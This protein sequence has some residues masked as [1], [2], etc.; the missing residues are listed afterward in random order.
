MAN[1]AL[2]RNILKGDSCGYSLM[3]ITDIYLANYGDV[4]ATTLAEDCDPTSGAT[5]ITAITMATGG[6]FFH[7]EGQKNSISYTDDL[8]VTDAGNKYRTHTLT[9]TLPG[10]YNKD[11]VCSV[12][13]LALGRFIAV[14]VTA[15]GQWL[16]LGRGA[17][18]EATEQSIAGG[19]D[20]NGV[21]I[22]LAADV[23]E[24]SVPL[25]A[26]A[27]ATVKGE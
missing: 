23:A 24:S 15:D 16:M 11:L 6:K 20:A 14:V 3:K 18:L 7:I 4:S 5:E 21:T 27:Q 12:D 25:S 13:A 26:A 2:N 22:T 10:G 19:N 9:F 8:V 1:C 17:G